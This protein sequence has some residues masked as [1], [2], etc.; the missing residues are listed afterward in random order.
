MPKVTP[1]RSVLYMPGA[2]TRALEKA[3]SLACDGI[4]FDLEDAVA[5]ASKIAARENVCRAVEEGG[6]G[7]RE[8]VVRV[9]GLDSLWGADDV[10]AIASLSVNALLFPKIESLGQIKTILQAVD[11]A[12][13]SHLP[14]WLMVETPRGILNIEALAGGSDRIQALVMGTSDLV[15]ELRARHTESRNNLAYALQRC[16]LAARGIGLDILDGVHLDFR[17]LE[18]FEVVCEQGLAMGFD[19]KT[20]IHPTQIE[21]ANRVFGVASEDVDQA[22]VVLN[23]WQVAQ[24]AGRGVAELDG[25][26]IENLHAADAERILEFAEALAGRDD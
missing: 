16:V 18:S 17:N 23:V 13:G 19:G 4:I 22:R 25:R 11:G 5:P 3:R 8:L 14:V 10:A 2:N 12:G 9:N 20:L 1:R 7:Y 26:L 15:K 21:I 24:E 6:Y